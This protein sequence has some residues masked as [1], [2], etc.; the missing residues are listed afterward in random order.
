MCNKNPQSS[1]SHLPR[2]YLCI[3]STRPQPSISHAS[4]RWFPKG[5]IAAIS[6]A[7]WT[8]LPEQG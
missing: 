1:P 8:Q 6:A 3:F 5:V 4:R 2:Y 7:L